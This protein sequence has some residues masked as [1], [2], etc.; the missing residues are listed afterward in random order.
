MSIVFGRGLEVLMKFLFCLGYSHLNG[1]HNIKMRLEGGLYE[2]GQFS[3][4]VPTFLEPK[5]LSDRGLP[6][7]LT[8]K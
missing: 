2:F 4:A 5:F 1:P 8:Y 6:I 3:P 7:D